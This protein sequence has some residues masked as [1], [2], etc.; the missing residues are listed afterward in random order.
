MIDRKARD[1]LAENFRHLICG[2]ISNDQFEDRLKKAEMRE[3]ARFSTTELG[4][5]TTISTNIN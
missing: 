3:Y 2:Q 4:R 5:F 1:I